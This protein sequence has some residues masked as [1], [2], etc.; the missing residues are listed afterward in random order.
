MVFKLFTRLKREPVLDPK[1]VQEVS[2][3]VVP[4]NELPDQPPVPAE[5]SQATNFTADAQPTP[6]APIDTST[7]RGK[8]EALSFDKKEAFI[9][10]IQERT[11]LTK[12]RENLGWLARK[13]LGREKQIHSRLRDIDTELKTQHGDVLH[14]HNTLK[15]E[16]GLYDATD[17]VSFSAMDIDPE[18]I[19]RLTD[20]LISENTEVRTGAPYEGE[21]PG[22]YN[23]GDYVIVKDAS[24]ETRIG[25]ILDQ[26]DQG[27]F[28]IVDPR[29]PPSTKN[30]DAN[31][32]ARKGTGN[33]YAD[34]ETGT[35]T[36]TED[37]KDLSFNTDDIIR[38]ATKDE[39]ALRFSDQKIE[40]HLRDKEN[41]FVR[42]RD[43]SGQTVIGRV[44]D[45]QMNGRLAIVNPN[46]NE[47]LQP[48]N[49][50]IGFGKED[51]I[52]HF[53]Q[54][55]DMEFS[56]D[57]KD[58]F[59]ETKAKEFAKMDPRQALELARQKMSPEAR[60]A[61]EQI[62][63]R[64]TDTASQFLPETR[65]RYMREITTRNERIQKGVLGLAALG[66]LVGTLAIMG[67][68]VEP[69]LLAKYA[70]NLPVA[71]ETIVVEAERAPQ[72]INFAESATF[73][74]P[75]IKGQ[76][77]H[78]EKNAEA[79]PRI[80][81]YPGFDTPPLKT[82]GRY[83]EGHKE[84]YAHRLTNPESSLQ[85]AQKIETLLETNDPN[86]A[87]ALSK[88]AVRASLQIGMKI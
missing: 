45:Q 26:D 63:E 23:V 84:K 52:E 77:A 22:V 12:K 50:T 85:F 58:W 13:I 36:I 65:A 73:E 70:E 88:A 8:W 67:K 44:V 68:T 62:E 1:R 19:R 37:P 69:R 6:A 3:A 83:L 30:P 72:E 80:D 9:G 66:I 54:K 43:V 64:T 2:G 34:D 38:P 71:S 27:N 21:V 5:D 60:Q 20:E 41:H 33:I 86:D 18:L 47:P 11:E 53:D 51:I 7:A 48:A 29:I 87:D 79:A 35:G 15:D 56:Q 14:L 59:N 78:A 39:I 16:E 28:D 46:N 57:E 4:D 49:D 75:I 74:T 10:L 17:S 61:I 76:A 42:V 81:Q 31:I 32:I 82:I 24:G 40:P 55:P 25:K